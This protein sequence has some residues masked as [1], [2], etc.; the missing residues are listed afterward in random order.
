[1][2]RARR[3]VSQSVTNILSGESSLLSEN[4]TT[5]VTRSES[6]CFVRSVGVCVSGVGK[7]MVARALFRY[8]STSTPF[9]RAT[10]MAVKDIDDIVT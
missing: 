1:M 2:K 7:P 3:G 10:V 5:A 9:H 8:P 4:A 6:D